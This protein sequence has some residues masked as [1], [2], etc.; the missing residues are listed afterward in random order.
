M[1]DKLY[2]KSAFSREAEFLRFW[3]QVSPLEESECFTK[4]TDL[5]IMENLFFDFLRKPHRLGRFVPSATTFPHLSWPHTNTNARQSS[6][7]GLIRLRAT[8]CAPK[9]VRCFAIICELFALQGVNFTRFDA[10]K[11]SS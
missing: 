6:A 9:P 5:N 1:V 10:G 11:R 4:L 8:L 7:P 3:R 2:K